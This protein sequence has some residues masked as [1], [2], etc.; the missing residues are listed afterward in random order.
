MLWRATE[1]WPVE[2]VSQNVAQFGYSAEEILA[3][4]ITFL[5]MVHPDDR[6]RVSAEIDAH[7]AAGHLEYSQE[8]RIVTRDGSVCWID[9]RTLVRVDPDYPAR[10]R[11]QR[12]EGWVDVEYT[13]SAAG[14]VR[15][16]RVIDAR[17]PSVFEEAA[18]TAIRRWRF[19]PR[20]ENGVPVEREGNQI[21]IR[22]DLDGGRR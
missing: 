8:Y 11:Q 9:D 12:I 15:N 3:K 7:A 5:A 21:R 1:G 4:H 6:A 10:A 13:I 19:N 18:L 20:L 16:P 14:T 17:P 2:F 22:F